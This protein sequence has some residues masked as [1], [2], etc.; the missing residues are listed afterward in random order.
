MS[1]PVSVGGRAHPPLV[2]DEVLEQDAEDEMC[3]MCD[4]PTMTKGDAL[5][6]MAEMVE[7][8]G[9]AIEA[10]G[11]DRVRPPWAY[12]VGLTLRGLPELVI[13]GVRAPEAGDALNEWADEVVHHGERLS[14]GQRLR[15]PHG[16]ETEIVELAHPEAHLLTAVSLFPGAPLR[17]QQLVWRDDRG[18]WPWD[19][20]FRSRRGGQPVLGPRSNSG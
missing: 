20:G 13:T 19:V 14:A 9:W 8:Y 12:T 7:K 10:V 18:Q 15:C 5:G 1:S 2:G 3:W 4:D 6:R 16:T 11:G 17:A